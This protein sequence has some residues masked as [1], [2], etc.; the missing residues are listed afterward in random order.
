[1]L[2][3]LKLIAVYKSIFS[4]IYTTLNIFFFRKAHFSVSIYKYKSGTNF[5]MI[6]NFI[7]TGNLRHSNTSQNLTIEEDDILYK[8]RVIN[9]CLVVINIYY[10]FTL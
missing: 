4:C 10:D 7:L 2:N 1:M 3:V 6:I 9:S 5:I 8:S